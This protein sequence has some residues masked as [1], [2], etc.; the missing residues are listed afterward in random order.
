MARILLGTVGTLQGTLSAYFATPVLVR[1]VS[2][3]RADDDTYRR[4]TDLYRKDTGQVACR[5]SAILEV[6][7]PDI[8]ELVEAGIHGL[9]QILTLLGI[10]ATFEL[11]DVGDDPVLWRRYR[12]GGQGFS[13][14]IT[15]RF[16]TEALPELSLRS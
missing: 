7:R 13:F 8:R 15:E 3:H 1:V 12:L 5:A 2:Q 4:R 14:L 6:D 11:E 10:P 9:G 16:V